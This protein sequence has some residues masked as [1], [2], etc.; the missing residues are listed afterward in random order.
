[1]DRMST[2]C[3]DRSGWPPLS[4]GLG[5][6]RTSALGKSSVAKAAIFEVGGVAEAVSWTPQQLNS[7]TFSPFGLGSSN[8]PYDVADPPI[9]FT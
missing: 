4:E 7:T 9:K 1:M 8:R 2:E 3:I 5:Q 6:T